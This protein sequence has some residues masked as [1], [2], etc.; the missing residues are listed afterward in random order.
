VLTDSKI[1]ALKPCERQ[2][3]TGAGD[4]LYLLVTPTGGKLWRL[5]YRIDGRENVVSFGQ[6]P[7]IGLAV[8][9]TKAAE[10][11]ALI[12]QGTHPIAHQKAVNAAKKAEQLNSFAAV[13]QA[14]IEANAKHLRPYT[15]SQLR[16]T[17]GR[18]VIDNKTLGSLPIR[19]V[20][21][22]DIRELLQS[23]ALRTELGPGERKKTAV[24]VARNTRMWCGKVFEYAIERDLAETDPTYPLRNLTELKRPAS[25]IKH[26]KKMTPVE[27]RHFLELLSAPKCTRQTAIAIELL[28]LFF[29]RTGELRQ[30]RWE[31]FDFNL[32]QW[33]IPASRMKA[34]RE[35]MVPISK[36][37][38]KLLREQQ[39]ISGI[40]GWV[41]P[42]QRT[43]GKCMSTTTIN[44]ALERMGLNGKGTMEL[45]AHGFR[46]TASTHL[47]ELGFNSDVVEKQLA[48][49]PRNKVKAI[50]SA[51]QYVPE[52][53]EMMQKWAD[54]LDSLKTLRQSAR[55]HPADTA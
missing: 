42:S 54:Y 36:Q 33:R 2:Y 28:L 43:P 5:K 20:Q 15:L 50:Y 37:A 7:E 41:F 48:H 35:H 1:K 25:S 31:E 34:G 39:Q 46:G 16:S 13:T 29:V 38:L 30:A 55:S 19:K 44:R 45:A 53:S 49:V 24:T 26:N 12:A 52:R 27:V 47:H 32:L 14:W 9:R 8:A 11:R 18:Y 17:M 6:Y 51:A 23:I 22:K 3:K 4:G 21:S 40:K 10:A